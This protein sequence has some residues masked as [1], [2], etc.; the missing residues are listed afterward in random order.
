METTTQKKGAP[1][2]KQSAPSAQ[3]PENLSKVEQPKAK[4][5]VVLSGSQATQI[6]QHECISNMID[7]ETKTKIRIRYLPGASTII[8]ADQGNIEGHK[9][10]AIVMDRGTLIV[11]DPLK[12]QFMDASDRNV[13]NGGN[14]FKE[15]NPAKDASE[16]LVRRR[17][18]AKAVSMASEGLSDA[19]ISAIARSLG[20]RNVSSVDPDIV[21]DWC[22]DFAENQPEVFTDMVDSPL[23]AAISSISVAIEEGFVV[24]RNNN[25][26][27]AW[28]NGGTFLPIPPGFEE[29]RMDFIARYL[30][31]DG[32]EVLKTIDGL[33]KKKK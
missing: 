30:L 17:F 33:I 28:A 19:K 6:I 12:M 9:V 3:L 20:M 26:E 18:V 8:A 32:V 31:T 10:E 23:P 2:A 13:A 14:I 21:R 5:Y 24:L 1:K 27:V 29:N 15:D 25:S 11:T 4:K 16:R 22:I 7:P